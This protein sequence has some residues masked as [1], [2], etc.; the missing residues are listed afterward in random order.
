MQVAVAAVRQQ[1]R[2][3]TPDKQA[4]QVVLVVEGPEVLVQME[5]TPQQIQDLAEVV[6]VITNQLDTRRQDLVG[7]VLSLFA[8]NLLRKKALAVQ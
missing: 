6:R 7:L 2:L 8:T 5:L 4:V 1:V 3:I